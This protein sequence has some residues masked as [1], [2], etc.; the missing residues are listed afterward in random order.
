METCYEITPH[1][2]KLRDIL[3]NNSELFKNGSVKKYQKERE[4]EKKKD[5]LRKYARLKEIKI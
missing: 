2:L 3:Q 5:R 1:K 4:R